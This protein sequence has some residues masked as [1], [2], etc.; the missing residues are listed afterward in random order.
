MSKP[1]SA[2]CITNEDQQ[3]LAKGVDQ[4]YQA[5]TQA[6][7]TAPQHQGLVDTAQSLMS[8]ITMLKPKGAAPAPLEPEIVK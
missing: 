6:P 4:L 5:S 7:L 1:N 8:L 2:C 3:T